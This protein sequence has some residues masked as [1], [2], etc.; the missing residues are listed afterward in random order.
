MTTHKRFQKNYTNG[1]IEIQL[2]YDIVDKNIRVSNIHIHST[3]DIGIPNFAD[4]S[5]EKYNNE[6]LI[7]KNT[8]ENCITKF[9]PIIGNQYAN[10]IVKD[11][12]LIKKTT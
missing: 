10:D 12:F 9:E 5:F 2:N 1:S 11:I 6:F 8:Y 3:F 4:L 7:L